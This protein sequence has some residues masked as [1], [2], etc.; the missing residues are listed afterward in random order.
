[1]NNAFLKS[2]QCLSKIYIEGAFSTIELNKVLNTVASSDKPLITKIVYGVL[3]N[4]ILLD[5]VVAQF[6][7]KSKADS[8]LMLK[9]GTYCLLK[10]SI[11]PYAV[12]ND[13]AELA[14]ITGDRRIVGFVNATLKNISTAISN[15]TISY[16]TDT[17]EALSVQYSY[18]MWAL[19]KVIKDYGIDSARAILS[20]P[21]PTYTTVRIN[22]SKISISDFLLLLDDAGISY[23]R[24]ML[25]DCIAVQGR[26]DMDNSLYT[27]MSL[28]SMLIARSV[29]T[30]GTCE[31]LDSCSAPGG[32]AVYIQQLNSS[33]TVTACELHPH[34][35][36][37]I[38]SYANRMG[39][40]IVTVCCDSRQYNSHWQQ[41][42]DYILC[43][44]PCS[45][46]G[47][48]DS[49]PDIKIFRQ[50]KDIGT[51]KALQYDIL[52]NCSSYL[53]VGGTLIYSTCTLFANENGDNV[54]KFIKNNSNF[55]LQPLTLDYFDG[56]CQYQFLP[57]V[58]NMQAFYLASITR[59]K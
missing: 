59:I 27:A 11:P 25:D 28:S 50:N 37:L 18:P 45:G 58:D 44:V 2:Y 52:Q 36:Q 49:R 32:K 16:P 43:D 41:K 7:T 33:A 56:A 31:V 24:T 1:M 26:L 13:M 22:T 40:D 39:A 35:V 14:K 57:H 12:V 6:V 19:L 15:D 4:D 54:A 29:A 5:Y 34:R 30:K 9:I 55:A 42:F 48:I 3:D 38:D 10:L 53:K 8:K 47:V 20:H 51:L 46:F 23:S 21:L 17:V